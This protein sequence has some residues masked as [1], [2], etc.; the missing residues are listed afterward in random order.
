M[1]VAGTVVAGVGF[2]AARRRTAPAEI[3]MLLGLT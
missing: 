2:E 1:L 3:V